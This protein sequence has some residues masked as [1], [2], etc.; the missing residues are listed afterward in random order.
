M[1]GQFLILINNLKRKIEVNLLSKE[2]II[3]N[4]KLGLEELDFISRIKEL[5]SIEVM[6][7]LSFLEIL[8]IFDAN[9]HIK[10]DRSNIVKKIGEEQLKKGE[11]KFKQLIANFLKGVSSKEIIE[12]FHLI[13]SKNE[14][15]LDF[16]RRETLLVFS[17]KYDL[18]N[19]V[20]E[21]EFEN[22]IDKS[23]LPLNQLLRTKYWN[24][25]YPDLVKKLFLSNGQNIQILISKFSNNSVDYKIPTTITK[26]E[27][28]IFVS[29]YI[30]NVIEINGEVLSPNIN[31]L[32]FIQHGVKGIEKYLD[33]DAD[34]KDK[35]KKEIDRQTQIVFSKNKVISHTSIIYTDWEEYKEAYL[36]N[37]M[38][39]FVDIDY[40]KKDNSY[41]TLLN[42]IQYMPYLFTE[43]LILNLVSFPNFESS[44]L[45]R[46]LSSKTSRHYEE[47]VFSNMKSGTVIT[48]FSILKEVLMNEHKV[49]FEDLINYFFTD[50]SSRFL[51]ITWLPL[52]FS[53][54][55]VLKNRNKVNYSIEENIRK[56]WKLL[57]EKGHIDRSLYN[58]E[59]TPKFKNLE[60][61]LPNKYIY[62]ND[63]NTNQISWLL[64]SDQS[65]L[66]YLDEQV[67]ENT[68]Y[69]LLTR[70]T[71][72]Y[73]DFR[74]Y[75]KQDLDF[76]ILGA[77]ITRDEN[78]YL[79]FDE[80]Q[81]K[82]ATI[83]ESIWKYGVIHYYNFPN[84]Y[85]KD[86]ITYQNVINDLIRK[87]I[88]RSDSTLFSNQES[89]YL[90]FLLNNTEFDNSKGIRNNYQHDYI[91]E[92]E[93]HYLQD[94]L[95]SIIVLFLYVVKINDEYHHKLIL[96]GEEGLWSEWDDLY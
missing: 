36:S 55:P 26:K 60:S 71:V 18:M 4:N 33:I 86:K 14:H 93:E 85:F 77:I 96:E 83:L 34:L 35:I 66:G 65:T 61:F 92:N 57:V 82:V 20:T 22:I 88:L 12:T 48:Q 1:I 58:Y 39:G 43:N 53:N 7:K 69:K 51:N 31:Y 56:Q 74:D 91:A 50:Y 3:T 78:D 76:L 49:M 63:E 73:T 5:I 10:K 52:T 13:Y 47:S 90:N 11:I 80:Y 44:I 21:I 68:L 6:K 29:E 30:E 28:Y 75:Q 32:M 84:I 9:N 62:Y 19:K 38:S 37:V 72:R 59:N 23:E 42:L 15:L 54:D 2:I 8:E 41:G 64:F 81:I 70:R 67:C 27:F 94:Y 87:N 40:I 16:S 24:L 25:K 89:E 95:Y 46:I 17:E 79:F 45:E